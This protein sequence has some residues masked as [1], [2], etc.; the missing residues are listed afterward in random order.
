MNDLLN[1][2]HYLQGCAWLLAGYVILGKTPY[3]IILHALDEDEG[4][5][6]HKNDLPIVIAEE[7]PKEDAVVSVKVKDLKVGE[8]SSST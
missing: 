7:V 6:S 2:R 4:G 5:L 1:G 3:E 8:S